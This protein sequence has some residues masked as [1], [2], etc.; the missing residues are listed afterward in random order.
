MRELSGDKPANIMS[1][2]DQ[3]GLQRPDILKMDSTRPLFKSSQH[4]DAIIC[5]PPY[6]KRATV[7][8]FTAESSSLDKRPPES[9]EHKQ[10]AT[11]THKLQVLTSDRDTIQQ[12][13]RQLSL[14]NKSTMS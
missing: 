9:S 7:K 5:D 2:F 1:N 10:S 4:F 13:H 8:E 11:S 3:Y 6:G 14:Q 12:R